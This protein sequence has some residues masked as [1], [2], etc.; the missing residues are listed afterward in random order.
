MSF[1]ALLALPLHLYAAPLGSR[2]VKLSR[3]VGGDVLPGGGLSDVDIKTSFIFSKLIP[4][5]IK[6]GIRLALALSVIALMIGGYQFMTSYGNS[7]K[8]QAAQKTI[9]FA[10]MGLILALTAMGIVT[11]ITTI[12]FT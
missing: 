8:R 1:A 6:Y 4:F 3:P 10:A 2:E 12:R 7:E 9:L 5:V 11:I